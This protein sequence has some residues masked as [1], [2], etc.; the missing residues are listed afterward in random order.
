MEIKGLD[1]IS[2]HVVDVQQSINF[3]GAVMGLIQ[4]QRPDFNFRGAWFSLGNGQTLHLIEG[5]ITQPH[6]GSRGTHIAFVV[7]DI[8]I[9]AAYFEQKGI[10]CTLIKE[11]PDGIK[12]FFITDPDGYCLEICEMATV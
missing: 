12:Q 10:A 6:W 2:L 5:R 8:V 4:V 9:A 1:H 3:Y 7:P 11:R